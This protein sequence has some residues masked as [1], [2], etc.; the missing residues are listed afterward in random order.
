M[1]KKIGI[2][3]YA[4]P[5]YYPPLISVVRLLVEEFDLVIISRNHDRPQPIYPNNVKLYRLGQLK[6]EREKQKQGKIK[7]VLEYLTFLIRSVFYVRFFKCNLIYSYDMHGFL[8]GLFASYSGKK[9]PLIYHNLDITDLKLVSGLSL[10]VKHFE[11]LFA[12]YANKI[13]FPDI[14]R[15]R[16][17]KK[18][19]N[20]KYLP[21]V[22]MNTPLRITQ[23]PLR[24]LLKEILISKSINEKVRVLSLHGSIGATCYVMELVQSMVYWP[25]DTMLILIGWGNEDFL[26]KVFSLAHSLNLEKRCLYIPPVPHTELFSYLIGSYLG[27]AL[28]RPIDIDRVY[29]AGGSNK[30]YE[31]L[32]LGIPVITNNNP[33]FREVIDE[34]LVYFANPDSQEDIIRVVNLAL[35]DKEG[36]LRKSRAAREAHLIKLNYEEQFRPIMAYIREIIKSNNI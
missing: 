5:D 23:L 22:V 20:L 17:F 26:Q 14:N 8:A 24:N 18:E 4:N 27:F 32:S 6:T 19:A 35:S 16:F 13:A 1:K 9:I 33:A 11:I 25:S 30:L 29:T 2:I 10:F 28:Y 31:C 36:Y 15:A 7:K 34:S 3:I 21:E 12:R